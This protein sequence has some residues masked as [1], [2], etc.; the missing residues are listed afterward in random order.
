MA[1]MDE[2]LARFSQPSEAV[3]TKLSTQAQK[4]IQ[5]NCQVIESLI[6][7]ILVCGMQGLPL[8]GHRDDKVEVTC[9]SE[10]NVG[11]FLELV[12]FR[13]ETDDVLRR[14]LETAPKNAK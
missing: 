1:K 4:N 7:V 9:T 6:K 10:E 11:N 14:H 12:R 8:R 5:E 13:A 2:F 3:S